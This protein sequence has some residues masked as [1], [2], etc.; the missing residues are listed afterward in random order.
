MIQDE[1]KRTDGYRRLTCAAVSVA[2]DNSNTHQPQKPKLKKMEGIVEWA[3]LVNQ[4]YL[5]SPYLPLD[6][7]LSWL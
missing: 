4:E 7:F 1:Y 2:D 5:L 3:D 6:C